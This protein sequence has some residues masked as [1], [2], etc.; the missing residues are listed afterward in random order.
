MEKFLEYIGL[1][2]KAVIFMALLATFCV[3]FLLPVM[4]QYSKKYTNMAKFSELADKIKVP[5]FS[6]CTGWKKAIMEK[7][8]IERE[9]FWTPTSNESNLPTDA[10]IRSVHS[11]ITYKLNEDFA[12]GLVEGAAKQPKSLML[13]MN[14]EVFSGEAISKYNVKEM[15]SF[16]YGMCYIIIPNE[17]FMTPYVDVLTLLVAKN[18]TSIKDKMDK[19]MVQISS[20]Y[21]F[22][23][24]F[25]SV[26]G[27]ETEMMSQD[28]GLGNNQLTIAYTGENTEYIQDCSEMSFFNCWATKIAMSEEFKCPKKC[29][30]FTLQLM[31]DTIDHNIPRCGTD[32][33]HYCMIGPDSVETVFKLKATCQKQCNNKGS[34][35]VIKKSE[36][37]Y[38][39]LLGSKQIAV[40][41]NFLPETVH[42]KE[43]LIFDGIGMFGSIGGSLGLFLGFSL[44]G[45]LGMIVDFILKKVNLV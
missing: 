10:T 28:F 31:M 15:P 41:L 45:T 27:M 17:T 3:L 14:E 22:L 24:I 4:T 33:E 18:N 32:A 21:S 7:Y 25:S 40:Y 38:P 8:K 44:F 23:T 20:K 26:A 35:L 11:D 34:K 6:I 13:G 19:V 9:F 42:N 36:Y 1:V 5:T 29:V 37:T 39:Y 12:I 30:P 2:V 16:K 43:Y